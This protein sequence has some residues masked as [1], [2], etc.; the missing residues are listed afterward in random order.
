MMKPHQRE[1]LGT[2]DLIELLGLDELEFKQRFAGMPMVR[3]KRRGLLR[4]VCVALGNI[5]NESCLPALEKAAQ[6]AEPLI[7]EH[8]RWAIEQI[9]M[10]ARSLRE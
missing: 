5:G 10:R 7:T 1:D 3:T 8:A 9:K 6:D 4:N 2:P